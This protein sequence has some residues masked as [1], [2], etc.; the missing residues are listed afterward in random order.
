MYAYK[1]LNVFDYDLRKVKA[2]FHT[3]RPSYKLSWTGLSEKL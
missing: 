3:S 1:T 2:F